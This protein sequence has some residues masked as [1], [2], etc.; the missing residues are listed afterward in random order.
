M[1]HLTAHRRCF[2]TRCLGTSSSFVQLRESKTSSPPE[3]HLTVLFV[4]KVLKQTRNMGTFGG[5]YFPKLLP[6][7]HLKC[8]QQESIPRSKSFDPDPVTT[9]TRC[10]ELV[11]CKSL[12]VSVNGKTTWW[13]LLLQAQKERPSWTMLSPFFPPRPRHRQKAQG[14]GILI[15]S[16]VKN[17]YPSSEVW[18]DI[19][20]K[21]WLSEPS[22]LSSFGPPENYMKI[23]MFGAFLFCSAWSQTILHR[24]DLPDE[25][26]FGLDKSEPPSFWPG[27]QSKPPMPT[28]THPGAQQPQ[29]V[30]P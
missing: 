19:F 13:N 5:G 4:H 27:H 8:C 2:A 25:L 20:K 21:C 22:C 14:F 17:W 6:H 12:P 11:N 15:F 1:Y 7:F 3:I 26:V 10:G 24:K 30:N 29:V 28:E 9:T 23:S 18:E 16:Q